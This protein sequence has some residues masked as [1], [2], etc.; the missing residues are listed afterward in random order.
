M[1]RPLGRRLGL[2]RR[3]Y[4]Q[5]LGA[6]SMPDRANGRVNPDMELGP[7][8]LGTRMRAMSE[9]PPPL[10]PRARTEWNL[11]DILLPSTLPPCAR[12]MVTG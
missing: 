12:A 3:G 11:C 1:R 7:Y 10:Q 2:V 8:A 9:T 4:S 6:P 5:I